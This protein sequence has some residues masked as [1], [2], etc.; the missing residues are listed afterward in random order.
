MKTKLL[1]LV[2]AAVAGLRQFLRPMEAHTA[3]A[4]RNSELMTEAGKISG[5]PGS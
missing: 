2:L 3:V 1:L 4:K 5:R